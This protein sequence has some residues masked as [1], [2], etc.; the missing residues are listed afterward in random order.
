[1]FRYINNRVMYREGNLALLEDT[2]YFMVFCDYLWIEN[3]CGDDTPPLAVGYKL[4]EAENGSRQQI[5]AFFFSL[6][7]YKLIYFFSKKKQKTQ[8]KFKKSR[9][10]NYHE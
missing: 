6:P 9:K 1:M 10:S 4:L 7:C 2:V 5:H 8:K 3:N